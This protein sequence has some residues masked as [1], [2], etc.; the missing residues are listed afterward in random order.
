MVTWIVDVNETLC[1]HSD[2]IFCVANLLSNRH[3]TWHNP[4]EH[5]KEHDDGGRVVGLLCPADDI[6]R[7]RS[8]LH[9]CGRFGTWSSDVLSG[10]SGSNLVRAIRDRMCYQMRGDSAVVCEFQFLGRPTSL[11]D[12]LD[13]SQP[14]VDQ[15][16]T[17]QIL[18]CKYIFMIIITLGSPGILMPML[19]FS[20]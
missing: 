5:G 13:G 11:S 6:Q 7:S 15:Q 12:V 4:G 3:P 10:S 1:M 16:L 18:P 2:E 14:I 19:S 9:C 17:L 8:D 20:F